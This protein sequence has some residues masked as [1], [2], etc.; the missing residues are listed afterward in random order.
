MINLQLA[1]LIGVMQRTLEIFSDLVLAEL[2][3]N[4]ID[5]RLDS[6][7]VPIKNV[8][9]LQTLKS[10]LTLFNFASSCSCIA[11]LDRV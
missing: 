2:L 8:T 5:D 11:V 6:L 1:L 9:L 7:D 4:S 10:D 3:L